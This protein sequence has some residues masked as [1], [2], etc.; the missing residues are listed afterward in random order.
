[1]SSLYTISK[2][3]LSQ[4]FEE[5]VEEKT[6]ESQAELTPLASDPWTLSLPFQI[7]VQSSL[8]S[9]LVMVLSKLLSIAVGKEDPSKLSNLLMN[10]IAVLLA[11]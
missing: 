7:P 8:H 2:V 11:S 1:M 6:S 3:D 4:S 9:V 5:R 10:T